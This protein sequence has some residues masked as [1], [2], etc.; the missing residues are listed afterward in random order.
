MDIIFIGTFYGGYAIPDGILNRESICYCAGAGEDISFEVGLVEKY[1]C[2]VYINDP[3]LRAQI[4]FNT[5]IN[6]TLACIPTFINNSKTICYN[7]SKKNTNRIFFSDVGLWHKPGKI[8]F[9]APKNPDHV[10]HSAI[11]LQKT[12]QYFTARVDSLKNIMKLNGHNYIDLLKIDIEG[13]E[14]NVINSMI[15]DGI[16]PRLLCVE[17]DEGNI[18]IDKD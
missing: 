15:E 9:Y 2:M 6:N 11:N 7:L 14:Y 18:P 3:T 16:S 10:S 5:L 1:G 4:H 13:A 17:Y 12:D 8:R